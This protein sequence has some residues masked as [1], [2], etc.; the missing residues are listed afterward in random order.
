[1]IRIS[2]RFAT[3][4]MVACISLVM[5]MQGMGRVLP[6]E[7]EIVYSA[8]LDNSDSEIY[9]M[10]LDRQLAIPL[11]RNGSEDN[12]PAWSS[13]G[14]QIA[15][16]SNRQGQFTIYVMDAL[17]RDAHRLT[18]SPQN[19]FSP[20][21]SPDDRAIAYVTA[22]QEFAQ[23]ITE[24]LMT[25]LQSG[26]TSRL[27]IPY[28]NAISPAWAPD[29]RHLAFA[30]GARGSSNRIIYNVDVQSGD[31]APL[32]ATHDIQLSP[33]WSPDGHYLL[34]LAY[35]SNTGMYLWDTERNQSVL[36]FAPDVL[37]MRNLSWSQDSRYIIYAPQTTTSLNGIWRL[38]VTTCLQAQQNCTP[39]ALT[40][41]TG[42]YDSPRWRP[43]QS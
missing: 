26:L 22:R 25:N 9:R 28:P 38:D 39:Q 30:S 12:Q 33:T 29:S 11:T 2:L 17:G 8:N 41:V 27:T 10:A 1:M 14:Q 32:I 37:N 36:L 31:T 35:G 16:V 21:W 43:H 19:N 42:I 13:D 6:R 15:F 4:A 7:E 20:T 23:Q 18:S 34:Y 3:L 40:H 5:L 24:V